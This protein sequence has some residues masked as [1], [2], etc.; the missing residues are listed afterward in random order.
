LGFGGLCLVLPNR[1]VSQ[2]IQTY[3]E[4]K[5]VN[6]T[7]V[8]STPNPQVVATAY[9]SYKLTVAAD[10]LQ[11]KY[12]GQCVTFA[13]EFTGATPD[14][15]GGLA[16][17]VQTSTTTPEIGAIVKTDES[18]FGHLAVVIGMDGDTLTVVESNYHWN[19][20]IDIRELPATDPKIVGYIIIND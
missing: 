13:R 10:K 20:R 2:T 4:V 16:R 6:P 8:L 11:G 17:N 19:E 12:G 14:V 5:I 7:A 15:V 18:R 9:E 3:D 1:V